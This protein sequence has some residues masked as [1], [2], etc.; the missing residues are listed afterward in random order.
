MFNKLFMLLA[1]C[2]MFN[3]IAEE[4]L[5][6]DWE[7]QKWSISIKDNHELI[8]AKTPDEKA[9]MTIKVNVNGKNTFR[10]ALLTPGTI[11]KADYKS[12]TFQLKNEGDSVLT[13]IS[14]GNKEGKIK[15]LSFTPS[16]SKDWQTITIPLKDTADIIPELYLLQIRPTNVCNFTM[17]PVVLKTT[18]GPETEKAKE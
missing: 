18:E 17:G 9:A 6:I 16:D 7:K 13:Q 12:I 14:M 8:P 10:S 3:A 5:L 2:C 4:T 1:A 11:P 15:R